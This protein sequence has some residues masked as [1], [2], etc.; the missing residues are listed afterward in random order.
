MNQQK[1]KN[2]TTLCLY[3]YNYVVCFV[4]SKLL[5]TDIRRDEN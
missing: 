1:K 2:L 3:V 5:E 4:L